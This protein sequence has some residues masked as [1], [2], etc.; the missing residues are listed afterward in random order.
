MHFFSL[1][2]GDRIPSLGLGTWKSAPGTVSAAVGEAIAM[3]YRHIDCAPI[4][5][6]EPEVGQDMA[7]IT[8]LDRH[9]RFVDGSFFYGP[10]SPYSLS[11]LWDSEPRAAQ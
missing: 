7:E 11:M 6:N 8:G 9:Y 1:N 3:G 2:S 10:G 5:Q 4:Y